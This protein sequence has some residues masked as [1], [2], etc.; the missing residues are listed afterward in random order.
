[1]EHDFLKYPKLR[2][3][4]KISKIVNKKNI[5]YVIKDSMKDQYYKFSESEWDVISLFILGKFTLEEMVHEFNSIH[6]NKSVD[7]ETIKAFQE[8]L[9]EMH[10]LVKSKAEMNVMLVEKM[11]EMRKSQLLGKQGSLFYKRFPLLDPDKFFD[12]YIPYLQWIWTKGFFIFSI[13]VMIGAVLIVSTRIVEF[14]QGMFTLFDFSQ[15]SVG[16]IILLWVIIYLTIGIHE[17]GHG[18]T[19]KY[20]G[21]EVHEIGFLLLFFQPCLYCNVNDAWLFDKKW[22][23]IM[24]TIAGGY[25]EFLIG[26][27]CTYVWA[28]SVPH[29]LIHNISFQVMTICSISTVMFNFNPLMKLD[30][31]YLISD[32]FEVPNLK[33]EAGSYI[34]YVVSKYI[35]RMKEEKFEATRRER[36]I[37]LIYGFFSSLWTHLQ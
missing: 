10:L 18:L 35:F 1:M 13:L 3:D 22:K 9:N 19:C 31:Y 6:K 23:Q 17:F 21:G 24:V 36:R 16:H 11:K 15:Q 30:G 28:L 14:K 20:Y 4:L 2:D 25:I 26:A 8:Q 33:E 7:L 12:K 34:S 29:S 32:F 37:F 27:M 5:G